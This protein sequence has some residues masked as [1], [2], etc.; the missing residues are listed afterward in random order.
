MESIHFELKSLFG[1]NLKIRFSTKILKFKLI[2][3]VLD[4]NTKANALSLYSLIPGLR[5]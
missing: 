5:P 3:N 1:V 4:L 2:T